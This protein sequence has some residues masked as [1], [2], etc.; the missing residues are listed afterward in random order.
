M[1]GA[2][3]GHSFQSPE[4]AIGTATVSSLT[5]TWTAKLGSTSYTSPA[6]ITSTALGADL[7]YAGADNHL[8]AYRAGGGAPVWTYKLPAGV[9]ETSP[10]EFRGVLYFGSTAGSIFAV[11]ASTG[12]LLC[13]FA[14]ARPVLAAPVVVS[15]PDGSGPVLYDGTI[16]GSSSPSTQ[17]GAEW[18]IYGPGN[19]HGGCTRDWEFTAFAVTP[20]GTWSSPAYGLDAGGKPLVVFGSK[21]RDDSVYA[22]DARTGA[23]VWRYQTSTLADADVGASPVISAPGQNGFADGVVYVTAKDKSV[24][25]LD[26]TTGRLIWTYRLA[27]GT[28]GD[29]S[30]AA[31]V[32][33]R[34]YL[35]S[36]TGVY[37]FNAVTGTPIW[38]VLASATFYSSPAVT[39]PAGQRVL[40]IGDT[41]GNL[42]ALNL[43][44]GA[45]LWTQKPN[46]GFWAS[47]AISHGAVYV[48]GL[49]GVLRRLAPAAAVIGPA[50]RSAG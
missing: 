16:P 27:A 20:G 46:S 24:Y 43:T 9:V 45:T 42:Y 38:H 37:A 30:S 29:L 34:I 33:N 36:D 4:T 39:G 14:T 50:H 10:A 21:D 6:V 18:A 15:D 44:T 26:L 48:T 11:N 19:S 1:F 31:L 23:L 12:A 41:S 32:G 13:S 7:V 22:L 47:P 49:D 8:Y 35:G 17:P 25:A 2:T 40:L 3:P 28:H 5:T